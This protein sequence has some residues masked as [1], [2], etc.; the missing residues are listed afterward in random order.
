MTMP[1]R[2]GVAGLGRAFTLMLPTFLLDRCVQLV[3][4]C[5][6][7][8]SARARFERDFRAPAYETV[9]ALCHDDKVQV[10][11]IA[12][13]HQLHAAHVRIAAAAGKHMLVEKPMAITLNECSTMIAAAREA[14]VHLIVGHSHSFN[15]PIRHTLELIASGR[16]GRVRMITALNFT[17]FLYRP[18][19]PEEL[20]TDRGGGVVHSQAAHQINVI[21]LLAQS[22]VQIVQAH[23]G[24]WDPVRPTEGAYSALLGF[25]DGSFASAT[26]SG[27][28]HFDSDIF[29]DNISEIGLAKNSNDYGRA[30]RRLA[31]M[32]ST[33]HEARLKATRNYGGSDYQ[34]LPSLPE[35]EA[36]QHFGVIVVS[37]DHA[38]LRPTAQGIAIDSD[39]DQTF[40]PLPA[41]DVPRKEVIDEL[42][43][44]VVYGRAPVHCGIWAR[45][46]TEACLAIL[47]SAKTQSAQR[48][49]Y[50]LTPTE[51]A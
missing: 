1:L 20:D 19:R 51:F 2:I 49:H 39:E 29:M 50:Q 22:P 45:A 15:M 3:A 46:T 9:E 12:T 37:C 33:E 10:V 24:A 48:M 35:P 42:C 40:I 31:T 16:Y 7:V 4:A 32:A 41:P 5:D 8:D 34:D 27:Y 13:P 18:R 30:R 47:E 25:A 23:T 28:G 44:A 11:Y 17:D 26:Y 38:D 6:P 43:D 21:R 36:H 14:G